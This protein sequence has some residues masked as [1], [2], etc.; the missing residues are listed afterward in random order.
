MVAVEDQ[1]GMEGLLDNAKALL[2]EECRSTR[3]MLLVSNKRDKWKDVHCGFR[4]LM[5]FVEDGSRAGMPICEFEEYP[6]PECPN[7]H[8]TRFKRLYVIVKTNMVTPQADSNDNA[9]ENQASFC[10][11]APGAISTLSSLST[12]SAGSVQSA[13]SLSSI[14]YSISGDGFLLISFVD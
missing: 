1:H 12:H 4:A 11:S 13:G 6:I 3:Y 7:Q 8:P 5:V 10:S 14:A 2:Q 9:L